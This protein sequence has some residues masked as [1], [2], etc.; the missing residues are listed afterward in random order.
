MHLA[1]LCLLQDV[2]EKQN[3]DVSESYSMPDDLKHCKIYQLL[4]D[5]QSNLTV[6]KCDNTVNVT[7][8]NGK[9]PMHV[10]VV[11]ESTLAPTPEVQKPEPPA[12]VTIDGKLYRLEK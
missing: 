4:S 6:L 3:I 8:K 5:R 9:T 2:Q 7:L 12:T 10:S 11:D 1:L